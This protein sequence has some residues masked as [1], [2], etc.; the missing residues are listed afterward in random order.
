MPAA[1]NRPALDPAVLDDADLIAAL[2][3]SSPRECIV[4]A[5]EAGSRRLQAA[6]APL[7][8]LCRRFAAWGGTTLVPDQVAA[9]DALTRIG[10]RAAAAAVALGIARGEF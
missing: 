6:V 5:H 1:Q 7:A 9:L 10:S 4:L 3:H 2:S 8:L